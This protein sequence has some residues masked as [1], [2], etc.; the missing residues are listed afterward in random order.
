MTVNGL[1]GVNTAGCHT[2]LPSGAAGGVST[3]VHTEPNVMPD[4]GER[5]GRRRVV[6]QL[7]VWAPR[8]RPRTSR[9]RVN[10]VGQAPT[11]PGLTTL[12]TVNPPA[13]SVRVLVTVNPTG[14]RHPQVIVTDA[15]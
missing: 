1:D 14:S 3:R 7:P 13:G 9:C 5:R 15:G 10:T 6:D 12:A 4:T 11:R 8:R 2:W